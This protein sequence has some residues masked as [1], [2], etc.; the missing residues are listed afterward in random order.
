VTRGSD[1]DVM[2]DIVKMSDTSIKISD[3]KGVELLYSKR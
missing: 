3:F 2:G 1:T